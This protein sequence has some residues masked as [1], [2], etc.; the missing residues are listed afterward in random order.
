M[1]MLKNTPDSS[2]DL[3]ITDPPYD[4]CCTGGGGNQ[5]HK[6]STMGA[7]LVDLNINTGYD[8]RKV[9]K[10]I[11]QDS[12][13]DRLLATGYDLELGREFVELHQGQLFR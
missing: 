1:E 4:V 7:D 3:I 12:L 8:I 5:G 11:V 2:I 13:G 9:G 10:E 6:I